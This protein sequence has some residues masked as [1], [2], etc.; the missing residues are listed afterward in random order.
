MERDVE[1][2]CK[3]CHGCQLVSRGDPP[4]PIRSTPLPPGSWQ[5]VAVDLLGPMP[6]GHSILVV[7]DYYSRFYEV[8]ILMST[9]ADK[10]ICSVENIF[11]RHG[12]PITVKS[13]NG[14]QFIS[15]EFRDFGAINGITPQRVTARWAQANCEGSKDL[16]YTLHI[17]SVT[18]VTFTQN[19]DEWV[20]D[21]PDDEQADIP[22]M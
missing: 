16:N 15:T 13:D 14:H 3:S 6:S 21:F 22:P 1:K 12:L 2:F 5:D 18:T 4:E 11:N 19:D 8:D 17:R 7:V 9:I 20:D 10:S